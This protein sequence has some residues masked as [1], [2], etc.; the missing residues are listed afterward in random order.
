MKY[1]DTQLKIFQHKKIAIL[2]MGIE[3]MSTAEFLRKFDASITFFDQKTESEIEKKVLER[4]QS[5]GK[6]VLGNN[7][8]EQIV[9]FDLIVRSPGIHKDE[10]F[11]KKAQE[12]GAIITSQTKLFFDL[13]PGQIIGVTGTKGKGTTST[14]IYEMLKKSGRDVYLGG[15]IGIP[16]IVFLENLIESSVVVLELS[17]FQLHDLTKSP[18]IAVMLMT[19]PEH[20]DYHSSIEDYIN[21][22]RN[23]LRFQTKEDFA[24][25]NRDYPASH[26]SDIFTDGQVFQVTRERS[27]AEQG[28]FIKENALWMTMKGAEWK[29]IDLDKIALPGKHN[30]E[31]AAAA[32][33]AATLAG[34]SKSDIYDIL[35]TFTGLEHRLELVGEVEGVKYYDDSFST[36]PETAI[37]AIGA[38]SEPKILILGGS[39]KGSDFSELGKVISDSTSIKVIIGIGEEWEVIKSHIL[40]QKPHVVLLEGAK[41]MRTVVQAAHKVA[42]PGDIVLLSPACA[43]F[44]M[45]KNYK[46]RGNLFKEEVS[47]LSN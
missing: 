12:D 8:F 9:G 46:E 43:S 14:L 15:N 23:N 22:K 38:F 32:A 45:F 37:A 30:V 33:M 5:L 17:S 2:G 47:R 40:N 20:Q 44:G 4:A 7:A 3:G 16:P 1:T 34:A 35:T 42:L 6:V 11:L 41:D 26:E 25:I 13:C 18:H 27:T 31:N 21:A 28:T 10:P 29:I 24:I 36:T 39:S 19:V